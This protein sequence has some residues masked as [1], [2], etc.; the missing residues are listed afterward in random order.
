MPT[1]VVSAGRGGCRWVERTDRVLLEV[2]SVLLMSLV[3]NSLVVKPPRARL[4]C[5]RLGGQVLC[6]RVSRVWC[7]ISVLLRCLS[8]D[9]VLICAPL[10]DKW[11]L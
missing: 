7:W 10:I 4:R 11:S 3:L 1:S 2:V 5:G 6:I 9:R 8:V